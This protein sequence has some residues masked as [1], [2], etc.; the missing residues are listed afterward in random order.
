MSKYRKIIICIIAALIFYQNNMVFDKI[1]SLMKDID[2]IFSK[3]FLKSKFKEIQG[4]SRSSR[5]FFLE[6][7]VL[8]NMGGLGM[9]NHIEGISKSSYT[10]HR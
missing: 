7:K 9:T 4:D 3:R 6:F 5:R 2:K 8:R 1:C 10:P